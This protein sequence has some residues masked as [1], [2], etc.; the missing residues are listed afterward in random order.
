MR[1]EREDGRGAGLVL[2]VWRKGVY[3]Y[4]HVMYIYTGYHAE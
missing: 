1:A 3:N 4:V 2:V